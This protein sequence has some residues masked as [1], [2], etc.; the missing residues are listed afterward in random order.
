MI[1]QVIGKLDAD[2]PLICHDPHF[3]WRRAGRKPVPVHRQ[4]VP[5]GEIKEHRR[6]AA[7]GNNP[8][9]RGIRFEPMLFKIVLPGYTL[10]AILSI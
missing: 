8:P 10:H 3:N 9:G 6:I 5:F 1:R 7:R 4:P 2:A